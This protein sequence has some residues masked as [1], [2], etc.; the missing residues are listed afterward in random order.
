MNRNSILLAFV[1]ASTLVT[2]STFANPTGN[3]DAGSDSSLGGQHNHNMVRG[4]NMACAHYMTMNASNQ[5]AA[6]NSM[7]SKIAAANKM[8]SSHGMA[9]KV[10]AGC[11]EH[12]GMMVHEVMENVMPRTSVTP[13]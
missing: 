13:H 2:G 7:R 8:L 3:S 1:A 4:R 6:V 11:K 5:T 9:K 10:A 12:P